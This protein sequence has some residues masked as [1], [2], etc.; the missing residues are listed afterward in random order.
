MTWKN[1]VDSFQYLQIAQ[2]L[3][4][5]DA[6][7]DFT[8]LEMVDNDPGCGSEPVELVKQT[9]LAANQAGVKYA[10]ENALPLC[11]S[12]GCNQNGFNEILIVRVE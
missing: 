8:C 3:A 11:G 1:E 4:K 7:F 9:R 12:G 2:M 5:H 10:G 6:T